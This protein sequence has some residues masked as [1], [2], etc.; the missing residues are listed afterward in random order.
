MKTYGPDNLTINQLPKTRKE[1]VQKGISHYFTGTPC[2]NGHN[3]PRRTDNYSCMECFRIYL[4][5]RRNLITKSTRKNTPGK[6]EA[7]QSRTSLKKVGK[8]LSVPKKYRKKD[9]LKEKARQAALYKK[10]REQIL[11]RNRKYRENNKESIAATDKARYERNREKILARK[12][13]LYIEK[14]EERLQYQREYRKRK[15]L[16]RQAENKKK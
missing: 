8:P 11:E 13:L 14:R 2:R 15:R 5:K 12:K 10:N 16:E 3:S 6:T 1:A 9:K 7:E 4:R